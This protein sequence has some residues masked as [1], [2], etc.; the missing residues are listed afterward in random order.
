M[1]R[2]LTRVSELKEWSGRLSSAN[3]VVVVGGGSVGVEIVG[4]IAYKFKQD[5][6]KVDPISCIISL[7][8]LQ[9][10]YNPQQ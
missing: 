2:K 5:T 1:F 4:A 8:F 7:A 10:K 6:S 9:K 3:E